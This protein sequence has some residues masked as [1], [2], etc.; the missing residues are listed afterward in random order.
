MCCIGH[1]FFSTAVVGLDLVAEDPER[2][3]GNIRP[4]TGRAQCDGFANPPGCTCYQKCFSGKIY[5]HIT[6][7]LRSIPYYNDLSAIEAEPV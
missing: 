4:V 3:H 2:S 1:D 6:T 7:P 5:P